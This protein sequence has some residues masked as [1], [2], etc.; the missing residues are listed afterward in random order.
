MQKISSMQNLITLH[1]KR[2]KFK[3]LCTINNDINITY[4]LYKVTKNIH[5]IFN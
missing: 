5:I 2:D 4:T 1:T 3:L